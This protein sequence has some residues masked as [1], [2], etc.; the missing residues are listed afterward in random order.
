M[1]RF[2]QTLMDPFNSNSPT[3]PSQSTGGSIDRIQVKHEA[4]IAAEAIPQVQAR[5]Y[6]SSGL[7]TY[8]PI[9]GQ[10]ADNVENIYLPN[11]TPT[12]KAPFDFMKWLKTGKG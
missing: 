7:K 10:K 4:I 2:S 9:E 5:I 11:L 1:N 3:I 6:Q 8:E 12:K